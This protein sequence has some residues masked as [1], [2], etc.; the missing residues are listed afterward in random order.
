MTFILIP[1]NSLFYLRLFL[2]LSVGLGLILY[3]PPVGV[4]LD[5]VN[6]PA[7]SSWQHPLGCDRL[8]RDV[9]SLYSYGVLSTVLIAIPA[10][11]AT[12]CFSL[13]V[14]LIGFISGRFVTYFL[15]QL[16]Y[17]FLSIPSLLTALLVVAGMGA[18]FLSLPIAII[19]SDWALGY[20]SMIARLR[21]IQ[22]SGYV[23]ASL[24][25]GGSRIHVFAR[26]I[27]PGLFSMVWYLFITGV[28]T[29]IMALAIF[30]FLGVDW[31][32]DIFGPGLGEQIAF[33]GDYFDRS[34]GAVLVPI[35]GI[36]LLV[37]GLGK[38]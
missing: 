16:S 26:H 25:M 29:V 33:S 30:S 11:I 35:L 2:A 24:A 8:G 32:G 18:N 36:I 21:E 38:K 28:P 37:I 12:L 7:F 5:L 10:R 19:L 4:D 3:S 6:L 34:P 31:S 13:F 1:Q 27:L 17:V 15:N 9:Y 22:N 23:C 14:A 20:E